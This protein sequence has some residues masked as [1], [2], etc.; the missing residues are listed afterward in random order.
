MLIT[1]RNVRKIEKKVERR[2]HKTYRSNAY[3]YI[4]QTVCRYGD[5]EGIDDI[6]CTAGFEI[7]QDGEATGRYEQINFIF[8]INKDVVRSL[9][10]L[11]AVLCVYIIGELDDY[12]AFKKEGN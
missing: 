9:N 8:K 5:F 1:K 4:S 12:S 3:F 7:Y 2:L 11:V 10:E 6:H